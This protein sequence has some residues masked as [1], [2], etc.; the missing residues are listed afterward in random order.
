MKKRSS[1]F[2]KKETTING[3]RPLVNFQMLLSSVGG[4]AQIFNQ[5]IGEIPEHTAAFLVKLEN[6]V[7]DK[8]AEEIKYAAHDLRSACLF[9]EMYRVTDLALEIERMASEQ[10]IN[11]INLCLSTLKGELSDA[12][13]YIREHQNLKVAV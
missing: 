12:L 10:K 3:G 9:L 8:N 5:F 6:A 13:K 2:R 4:N 7:N 1:A 11:E